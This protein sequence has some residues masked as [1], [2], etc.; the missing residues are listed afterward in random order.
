MAVESKEREDE[1]ARTPAWARRPGARHALIAFGF[2]MT[3]IGVVGIVVPGLPTTIFLIIALWAFSHSSE[4]FHRWLWEHPRLGPP[5]RDWQ[6]HRVIPVR[7]K[8]LAVA[9]MS[10]SVAVLAFAAE[11]PLLA[12]A[13]A[14]ILVPIALYILTRPSRAPG[15]R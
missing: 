2:L 4:R 6:M 7:A 10:L 15:A 8:L 14:A 12:A 5:L 9:V 13:V 1:A 3:G 11:T